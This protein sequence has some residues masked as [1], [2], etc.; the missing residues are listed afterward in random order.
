MQV[1]AL[2]LSDLWFLGFGDSG[3]EV[4]G[5]RPAFISYRRNAPSWDL[6]PHR[7]CLNQG[8]NQTRV[9]TSKLHPTEPTMD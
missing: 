6:T 1:Y 3:A 5:L 9:E 4:S 7:P 8:P 2:L